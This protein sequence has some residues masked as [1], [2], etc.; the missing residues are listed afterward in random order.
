M[1]KEPWSSLV[2]RCLRVENPAYVL[3][4]W[5]GSGRTLKYAEHLTLKPKNVPKIQRN[6]KYWLKNQN[7]GSFI[8][9]ASKIQYE[10]THVSFIGS[11]RDFLRM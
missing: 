8:K 11:N 4:M 10:I 3:G 6:L 2:P 5:V 7:T 1:K 9:N